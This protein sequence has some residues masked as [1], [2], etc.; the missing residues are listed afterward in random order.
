M[1]KN[2]RK[3]REVEIDGAYVSAN[4]NRDYVFQIPLLCLSF[5][6]SYVTLSMSF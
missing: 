6:F 5:S 3:A 2:E 4:L 1:P